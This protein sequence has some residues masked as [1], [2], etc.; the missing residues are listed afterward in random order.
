MLSCLSLAILCGCRSANELQAHRV[1]QRIVAPP[2]APSPE[3]DGAT[4]DIHVW[5][6]TQKA[7]VYRF[8]PDEPCTMMHLLFKM[9]G[10]SRFSEPRHLKIIRKRPDGKEDVITVDVR[11][12]LESGD[13]E[14]DIPLQHGDKVVHS[15][16]ILAI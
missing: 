10:L 6:D 9:G 15:W 4:V 1:D 7:G 13:P 16:I 12:I 3:H 5:I 8:K 2:S 11:E 14:L